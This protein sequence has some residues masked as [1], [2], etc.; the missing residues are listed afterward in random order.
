MTATATELPAFPATR[1]DPLDPPPVYADWR[2]EQPVTR[3]MLWTGQQSWVATRYDD[4]RLIL[5]DQRFSADARRPGFPVQ[6]A[7]ERREE[8]IFIRL[9]PPEHTRQRRMLTGEFLVKRVD[10]MRPAI[11]EIV[12]SFLVGLSPPTD[13]VPS[14][15]LPVPSLVICV[16]LGVPYA[17]HDFFQR[18]SRTMLDRQSPPEMVRKAV[19]DLRAYLGDLVDRKHREPG[20]DLLTRLIAEHEDNGDL[21]REQVVS[22][23]LLLLVA[24]HETTAN[25]IGLSMLTLLRNPDQLAALRTDPGLAPR[26]VEE[27]LRYL[28]VVQTGVPRVALTDIEL[29]GVTIR[30]GDPVFAVLPAANRDPLTFEHPDRV[31]LNRD[32]HRHVAFGYGAHQCL[33][34]PLA[35][36]ELQIAL[37]SLLARFPGIA[38]V[39]AIGDIQFRHDT[40]VYGVEKLEVSW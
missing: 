18:C 22:M 9:D 6:S 27:L 15:A 20:D 37:N 8:P 14:F 2:R 34:Q 36:V 23:A 13:L 29:G 7:I 17:D 26:A 16:M 21:N 10:E 11:Q 30:E 33:G 28:S 5:Q 32:A 12:D 31:D 39:D 1:E 35:R 4:V 19:D 38:L 40:V 25:M 3:A 24:G